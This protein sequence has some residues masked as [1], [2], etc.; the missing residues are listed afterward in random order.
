MGA[1]LAVGSRARARPR[2]DEPRP[3]ATPGSRSG[4]ARGAARQPRWRWAAGRPACP[5]RLTRP[6]PGGHRHDRE[7]FWVWPDWKP[8]TIME[9]GDVRESFVR[10]ERRIGRRGKPSAWRHRI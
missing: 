2:G 9:N 6:A 3:G 8:F 10:V 5:G 1:G 4:L 7:D